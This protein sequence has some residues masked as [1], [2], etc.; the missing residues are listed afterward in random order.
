MSYQC[1]E[2]LPWF[3]KRYIFWNKSAQLKPLYHF[4]AGI[5]KDIREER[6]EAEI[7]RASVHAGDEKV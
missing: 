7:R 4:E 6:K 3:T 1:R 5:V 2:W